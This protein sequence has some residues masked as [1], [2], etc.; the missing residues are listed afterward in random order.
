MIALDFNDTTHARSGRVAGYTNPLPTRA[1]YDPLVTM[2]PGDYVTVKPCVATEWAYLPDGKT[3]RFKL[4]DDVTFVSGNKMT[5]EDVRF[6]FTRLI[7]MKYQAS[8]Y[9]AH[10]DHVAVV[11]DHTVDFVLQRSHAAAADDHRGA[12]IRR[13][14]KAAVISARRHR[15]SDAINKDTATPWLDQN[16]AGTGAYPADR[17]AAQPADPDGAQSRLLGRQAGLR[18]RADPAHERERR[19]AA[20]VAAR[21]HRRRLQPD[22]RAG[23]RR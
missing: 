6:S 11:D 22:P 12:G 7:N 8:Q 13:A 1:A 18:A 23:R 4:R 17:L 15:C 20:G 14:E 2:T 10:V 5:A 9:L 16:S 3:I 19:A 21:R